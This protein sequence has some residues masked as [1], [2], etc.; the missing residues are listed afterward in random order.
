MSADP[1]WIPIEPDLK[2]ILAQHPHPLND[3]AE[4][5]I[6]AVIMRRASTQ[7]IVPHW[8]GDFT[9]AAYFTSRRFLA[10][11]SL[12]R[13]WILVPAWAVI[14]RIRMSFFNMPAKLIACL[15]HCLMDLITQLSSYTI[16]CLNWLPPS[17]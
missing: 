3:L 17:A 6:P 9:N 14:Q 12:C 5:R 8:L 10:V 16:P 13:A 11:T 15:E 1:E 7:N 4:G 2:T